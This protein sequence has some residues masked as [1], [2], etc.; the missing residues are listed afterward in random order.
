MHMVPQRSIQ[1]GGDAAGENKSPGQSLRRIALAAATAFAML[2][3]PAMA[4]GQGGPAP[5]VSVARPIVKEVTEWND[6]IGRFEA[7]DGVDVKARVS[8]YLD[9][10]HFQDGAIVKAGDLLFTIDQRTYR[11]TLAEA[12]A[13]LAAARAR[14]EFNKVDLSRAEQLRRNGNIPDQTVDQRKQNAETGA[15]EIDRAEAVLARARL[16][17]EFTEIRAPI[18]GRVS[19]RLVSV[20]SL[21]NADDT[22]LVNIVS[23]DPIQFYFDVDER[24]YLAYLR[25]ATQKGGAPDVFVALTNEQDSDRRGRIDFVDN[26]LDQSS[27]TMRGRALF[28]NKDLSLVPGLF[29]RLRMPGS[30]PYQAVLI[31]DEAI[32]TDQDRRLVFVVG[33]DKKAVPRPVQ[34]G[35]RVDGYRVVREGLSGD[36]TVIINGLARVRPGAAV[37]PKLANLPPARQ[38]AQRH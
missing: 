35:P 28:D 14:Q 13:A 36:D 33:E 27:G 17:I 34:I 19:R 11:A 10:V 26:R 18:S 4:L 32:A 38:T 7:V 5:A 3:L 12:R 9:K 29:G 20:G 15:A 8:G 1:V 16:D 24:S 25:G 23:L 37:E 6:F 21:V 2:A 31:P 22:S 30:Q